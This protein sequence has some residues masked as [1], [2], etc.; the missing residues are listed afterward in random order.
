MT[1]MIIIVETN[2]RVT[3]PTNVHYRTVIDVAKC[4][5]T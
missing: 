5:N 2:N 4:D 3:T 1:A